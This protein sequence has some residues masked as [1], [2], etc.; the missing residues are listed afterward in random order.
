MHQNQ[1]KVTMKNINS[2]S[3]AQP[4]LPCITLGKEK[5]N[6]ARQD[7]RQ[8]KLTQHH[9]QQQQPESLEKKGRQKLNT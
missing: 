9:H 3:P 4:N 7:T 8:N 6:S 1:D 2:Q 5:T